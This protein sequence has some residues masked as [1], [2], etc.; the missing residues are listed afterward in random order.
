MVPGN[1]G[2]YNQGGSIVLWEKE[3]AAPFVPSKSNENTHPSTSLRE[4]MQALV[5]HP[6]SMGSPLRKQQP[7]PF[8]TP[9]CRK[10]GNATKLP[11]KKMVHVDY[12]ILSFPSGSKGR[13]NNLL[14]AC[15]YSRDTNQR[16]PYH[17]C[18]DPSLGLETRYHLCPSRVIISYSCLCYSTRPKHMNAGPCKCKVLL[19]CA[20]C[21][22]RWACRLRG[23]SIHIPIAFSPQEEARSPQERKNLSLANFAFFLPHS[24]CPILSSSV[25]KRIARGY[26]AKARKF[27]KRVTMVISSTRVVKSIMRYPFLPSFGETW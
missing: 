17:S 16:L 5:D 12:M 23:T 14:H 15:A 18:V 6:S 20:L 2:R 21:V 24:T 4:W 7:M 13:T 25:L 1:Q 19:H 22:E 9:R 11:R 8:E 26:H 27:C 10:H 3:A